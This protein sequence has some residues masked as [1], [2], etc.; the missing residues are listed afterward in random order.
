MKLLALLSIILS[1][2]FDRFNIDAIHRFSLNYEGGNYRDCS[3]PSE[4]IR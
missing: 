1:S 2:L 3:F 4:K